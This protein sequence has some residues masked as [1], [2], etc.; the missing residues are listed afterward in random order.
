M[1]SRTALADFVDSYY[2]FYLDPTAENEAEFANAFL[3]ARRA[4]YLLNELNLTKKTVEKLVQTR[5]THL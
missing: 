2:K 4:G 1:K 5:A 3:S